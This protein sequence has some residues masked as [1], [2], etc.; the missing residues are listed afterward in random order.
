[1]KKE[2]NFFGQVLWSFPWP[3]AL[4]HHREEQTAPM[5]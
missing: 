4:R 5:C 1:M 3:D 2:Q